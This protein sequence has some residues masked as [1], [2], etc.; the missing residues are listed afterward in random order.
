MM[1]QRVST[2]PEPEKKKKRVDKL[3]GQVFADKY[4]ILQKIGEG[5]MGS[6]Y[7]ATQEPIDRKVAIKV[8]L[9]KLADDEIA[10]KRFEQEAKA[11][12]KMQHPNTVTIYDFGKTETD[13]EERFYIV[14][15]YLKGKTLTQVLR[16]D[17]QLAAGRAARIIRQV[18]ASLS[19]AH[20]AGIIHRDLKPDNIFLTE[21]GEDKDWVKVLDFGVAK[22][23]DAEGAGTL[24]QTGMI[25][26]TPKYM[27]PEQAEGRPIDYRADIYALGV[28]LYELLV[29]RPPF[30]AD[31][32][33]GLL[34]K[35]ISEPPPPFKKIRPDLTVDPRMEG[36]VMR[37][38]DKIPDR[39]QQMVADLASELEQFERSITGSVQIAVPG[40]MTPAGGT[41]GLPTEVVPGTLGGQAVTPANLQPPNHVPSSLSLGSQLPTVGHNLEPA[42][43]MA[44][45]QMQPPTQQATA[46]SVLPTAQNT[47][48]GHHMTAPGLTAP[49][50][51]GGAGV[52]TFGGSIGGEISGPVHAR[53]KP[54]AKLMV[55]G[56]G[57]IVG[58]LAL[59]VFV[60]QSMKTQVVD[61]QVVAPPPPLTRIDDPPPPP[62]APPVTPPVSP[63]PST[64]TVV[65]R[66]PPTRVDP[67]PP[68]RKIKI[69]LE[70]EPSQALV[71]LGGRQVGFTPFTTELP[72]DDDVLTFV[73]EKEGY[74]RLEKVI[75]A[76]RDQTVNVSLAKKS[77]DRPPPP[78]PTV[79]PPPPPT[80][81]PPPPPAP[82]DAL[83]E[84]VDDIK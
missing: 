36:I 11:I 64:K 22:L 2:P 61:A 58:S 53:P 32:P 42:T 83:N 82:G 81:R 55:V 72:K 7:I 15:E 25:F 24:T 41:P 78:P 8:L 49:V 66:P 26:G 71:Y 76:S 46:Q 33:V 4:K 21:V 44:S 14:M 48:L 68:A 62:V 74:T 67:P 9:G 39:R 13:G 57:L 52:D 84:R 77:V 34:L 75:T 70:S 40:M 73:F 56:I 50:P 16:K 51:L 65:S 54:K 20:G 43:S 60:S 63:P 23:A 5:G 31:T 10:V 19:D 18:C 38:L 35:H 47:A 29:G 6:V 28:V 59:A 79:R 37:A 17:G 80:V 45:A 69:V 27:S 3:V 1:G 12:S 30:V